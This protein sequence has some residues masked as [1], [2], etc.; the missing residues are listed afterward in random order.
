MIAMLFCFLVVP[1]AVMTLVLFAVMAY[2]RY[3]D[4]QL[5]A[6]TDSSGE[7]LIGDE[8]SQKIRDAAE[9]VLDETMPEDRC[10]FV[11]PNT[12]GLY[13][14]CTRDYGHEG[15][16]AHDLVNRNT[17]EPVS[18]M[19]VERRFKE[20]E[21]NHLR[22]CY[23]HES[24]YGDLEYDPHDRAVAFNTALDVVTEYLKD[25]QVRHHTGNQVFDFLAGKNKKDVP[26]RLYPFIDPLTIKPKKEPK[27]Y[28]QMV[29]SP[30]AVTMPSY[31]EI[32]AVSAGQAAA[33]WASTQHKRIDPK[34][35]DYDGN[36]TFGNIVYALKQQDELL[37]DLK[38][39]EKIHTARN[40]IVV[41]LK[42]IAT[43][44]E[45]EAFYHKTVLEEKEKEIAELKAELETF[46]TPA[47]NPE[48]WDVPDE[49]L[50]PIEITLPPI[51]RV[52]KI[53]SFKVVGVHKRPV[54]RKLSVK[55][56]KSKK[57]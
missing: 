15:P 35:E 54:K 30:H 38:E 3:K 26:N 47:P 45:D 55:K 48:L 18:A 51:D 36:P 27:T 33:Q 52:S 12:A 41:A 56:K 25:K 1:I 46:K 57:N 5:S 19:E 22:T 37:K 32:S 17:L 44:L 14:A 13:S 2:R 23:K 8:W 7:D 53:P 21:T 16:C 11:P 29:G 39:V 20:A 10:G 28:Q 34:N 6:P 43:K 40:M 49:V 31:G 50:P 24:K 4:N 9:S 42:E